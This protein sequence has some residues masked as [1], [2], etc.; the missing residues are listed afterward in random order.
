MTCKPAHYPLQMR[1]ASDRL[2]QLLS[3]AEQ[4]FLASLDV[5]RL[6]GTGVAAGA[7]GA[8]APTL[9]PD[10]K[11]AGKYFSDGPGKIASKAV[12]HR[13]VIE[14]TGARDGA[15]TRDLRRD[16]PAL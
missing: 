4:D 11:R 16:R 13:Q 7:R 8:F 5:N 6:A 1:A 12:K 9:T 10:E 15:R 14:M 3:G 2:P